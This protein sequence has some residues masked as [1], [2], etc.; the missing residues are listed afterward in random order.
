VFQLRQYFEVC[1]ILSDLY[2][3]RKQNLRGQYYGFLRFV[4]VRNVD[5][6]ALALNNVR[7]G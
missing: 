1:G 3:A 7:I 4:N 5:K 2:I 6:L